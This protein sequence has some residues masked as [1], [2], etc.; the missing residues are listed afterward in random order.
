MKCTYYSY[1]KTS[2]ICRIWECETEGVCTVTGWTNNVPCWDKRERCYE[3]TPSTTSTHASPLNL[4]PDMPTATSTPDTTPAL[5][6]DISLPA[7]TSD[8]TPALYP[9]SSSPN[10][11]V[12][13]VAALVIVLLVAILIIT[14][15][16]REK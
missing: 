2:G 1:K 10:S 9:D 14:C 4:Y 8:P 5:Y 16:V 6:P 13:I 7:Y 11:W 12:I 3:D 15:L